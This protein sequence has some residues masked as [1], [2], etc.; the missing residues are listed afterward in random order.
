MNHRGFASELISW[1]F[2]FVARH[3]LCQVTLNARCICC[4]DCRGIGTQGRGRT[5]K[6]NLLF[7][8]LDD[9]LVADGLAV[10]DVPYQM[11]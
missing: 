11:S 8:L 10:V 3:A 7:M 1:M 6:W 5:G 9:V 2:L 4:G